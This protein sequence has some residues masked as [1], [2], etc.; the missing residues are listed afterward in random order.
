MFTI[1]SSADFHTSFSR[2]HFRWYL[3]SMLCACVGMYYAGCMC[4]LES[5]KKKKKL[6]GPLL[7]FCGDLIEILKRCP[8]R[9][10]FGYQVAFGKFLYFSALPPFSNGQK[11]RLLNV[12]ENCSRFLFGSLFII[13]AS[14]LILLLYTLRH[15]TC[16][17]TKYISM[18]KFL[19]T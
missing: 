15:L 16:T 1:F 9:T 11:R 8:W 3:C 6:P 10:S 17:Y 5:Q 4:G 2:I 12:L 18:T 19:R 13:L 7:F 14:W